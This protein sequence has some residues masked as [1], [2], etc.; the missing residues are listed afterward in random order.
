MDQIEPYLALFP[1]WY[2]NLLFNSLQIL[3]CRVIH[4]RRLEH[5]L[6]SGSCYIHVC[7]LSATSGGIGGDVATDERPVIAL[8]YDLTP[9]SC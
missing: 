3:V 6:G 8:T 5:A 1:L 4:C 2:G 9:D 7:G